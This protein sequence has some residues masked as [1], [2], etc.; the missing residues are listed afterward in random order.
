MAR[1][2]RESRINGFGFGFEVIQLDCHWVGSLDICFFFGGGGKSRGFQLT[3]QKVKL[4]A[5]GS[6]TAKSC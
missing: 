2:P 5:G 1:A 3:P 4:F 6:T